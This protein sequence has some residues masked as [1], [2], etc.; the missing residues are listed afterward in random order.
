MRNT[1]L[2]VLGTAIALTLGF[3]VAGLASSGSSN[4]V[5]AESTTAS[6][7]ETPPATKWK[8]TLTTGAETPK[9]TGVK[10]G[11]GGTFDVTVTE[12]GGTY[13]AKWKLSFK[14][15]TGK[16]VAAHIHKGKTGKAGPVVVPLCGPCTSGKG[17]AAKVSEAVVK[18]MKAGLAYVNVHTAKNAAGEIRGQVKK[19]G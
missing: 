12:S 5:L 15:L 9:P 19:I 2:V 14:S 7:T 1:I 10:A 17:G 16:A 6:T 3:A 4:G 13:T 18:A 8:A 11:A